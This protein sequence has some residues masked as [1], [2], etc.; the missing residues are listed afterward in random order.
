MGVREKRL[1]IEFNQVSEL[2]A[3]SS[4]S[5]KLI[6]KVG[7][8]P[9]EYIIEYQCKGLERIN[10]NSPVYR[11]TH[12]VKIKLGGNYPRIKPDAAFLTSIFHPNVYPNKN[13]CL[14]NYWTPS[15][16]LTELILRIGKIIQYSKDVLNLGS[17]ANS[18]AKDW[19]R[20]NMSRFPIDS[21]TFKVNIGWT[22]L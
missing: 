3:N 7:N 11:N 8:P 20:N 14:G 18:T 17:P 13:I 12:Q 10:G 1:A 6:S 19:A 9:H 5:L 2:I 4:G 15:E 22:D 21:Q 16:T